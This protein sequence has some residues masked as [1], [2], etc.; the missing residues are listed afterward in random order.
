MHLRAISPHIPSEGLDPILGVPSYVLLDTPSGGMA[1]TVG[2]HFYA[3]RDYMHL[4]AISP[5][6]AAFGR[7]GVVD[8]L[9]WD[10]S[11]LGDMSMD[12][13]FSRGIK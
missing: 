10:M 4:G 1:P 9:L 12:I 6:N 2:M 11:Q 13:P 8:T 3:S 5:Y 7:G